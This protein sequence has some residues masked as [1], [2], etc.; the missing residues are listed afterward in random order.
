VIVHRRRKSPKRTSLRY[1][2]MLHLIIS[3]ITALL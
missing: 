3:D 2:L 1:L